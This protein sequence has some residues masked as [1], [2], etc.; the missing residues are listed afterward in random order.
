[1]ARVSEDYKEEH[2]PFSE[3]CQL[4]TLRKK[5]TRCPTREMS[6]L[7]TEG[8]RKL[9]EKQGYWLIWDISVIVSSHGKG[10][11]ARIAIR[12]RLSSFI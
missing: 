10:K 12:L 7:Y 11:D 3:T 9:A 8:D 6:P 2:T 1:L 5:V 4:L